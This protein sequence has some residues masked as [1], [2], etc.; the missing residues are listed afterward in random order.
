[1]S[2]NDS[3]DGLG[4]E[5]V[6]AVVV[7]AGSGSRLGGET[8]KALRELR[9]R[10]LV[11][12]AVTSLASA[13][14]T[15]VVVVAPVSYVDQTRAV[16]ADLEPDVDLVVVPGG[17]HRQDSVRRGLAAL[18]PEASSDLVVLVHDAA[19]PLVPTQVV[20]RVIAAVRAGELAVVPVVPVTDT[21]RAYASEAGG[22]ARVVDRTLLRAVQ[23]PQGFAFSAL[24]EAHQLALQT[25]A[26]LTDDAAVCELAGHQVALVDGSAL[27]FKITLPLDLALAELICAAADPR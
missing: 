12:R 17:S 20:T 5:S 24:W 18:D 4:H 21:I 8:P 7:A 25:G 9:G 6:V 22:P 27:S 16:L 14:V 1:M 23:T 13:G 2:T 10:S 11:G 26:E 15:R 19:R 3:D